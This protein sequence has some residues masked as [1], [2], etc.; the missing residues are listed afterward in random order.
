M[1]TTIFH[2]KS[3]QEVDEWF[4]LCNLSLY[5]EKLQSSSFNP[6]TEIVIKI[7]KFYK[8]GMTSE[9]CSRDIAN[10]SK[11]CFYWF[12]VYQDGIIIMTRL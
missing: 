8:M 1:Y 5:N 12:S 6:S 7:K 4:I 2:F 11:A 3:Y 9:A 10:A